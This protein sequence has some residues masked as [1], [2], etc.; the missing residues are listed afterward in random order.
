MEEGAHHSLQ[1]S[2][3]GG[4]MI[5]VRKHFLL[6][7]ET[8][9]FTLCSVMLV[10]V[11][12]RRRK[13]EDK[14][15]E[16]EGNPTTSITNSLSLKIV[17]IWLKDKSESDMESSFKLFPSHLWLLKIKLGGWWSSLYFCL[18]FFPFHVSV[19]EHVCVCVSLCVYGV[20][21]CK[22][23]CVVYVWCECMCECMCGM[24]VCVCVY[25]CGVNVYI[26]INSA[27]HNSVSTFT[28]VSRS[29][30][31]QIH[32]FKEK[33][34]MIPAV[35]FFSY[36]I[37]IIIIIMILHPFG[38]PN[39]LPTQTEVTPN[40]SSNNAWHFSF[41]EKFW[42]FIFSFWAHIAGR[43]LPRVWVGLLGGPLCFL[44]I[45]KSRW[46]TNCSR[47]AS[48]WP[49]AVPGPHKRCWKLTVQCTNTSPGL[50]R[51]RQSLPPEKYKRTCPPMAEGGRWCLSVT[52]HELFY[53]R[54]QTL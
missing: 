39:S 48:T 36:I 44:S 18:F 47:C 26:W 46:S 9:K 53:F 11:S 50:R 21:V 31:S 2:H 14:N 33:L 41:L 43:D 24:N 54:P 10:M 16:R 25:V 35:L 7:S 42:L 38:H 27:W 30:I 32:S 17:K 29:V 1:R 12:W 20:S 4:F 6:G 49:P 51:V 28:L 19:C 8:L 23:M 34:T 40:E 45:G 5:F 15:K 13:K 22:C 3:W 52:L 37:I